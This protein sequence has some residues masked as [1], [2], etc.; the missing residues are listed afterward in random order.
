MTFPEA[1]RFTWADLEAF[2]EDGYRREII[3]G[4]LLVTPAPVGRHQLAVVELVA[5]LR[6][7]KRADTVV[8][9]APYDWH[10]PDGGDVEPDVL[11]I[12]RAD[13]DPDGPLAETA[14]P[15]LVVEVLSPSHPGTDRLLKRD[16]Y[17]RFGVPA[18]W[19]V[20]PVVPAVT[21]LWL[22]GDCYRVAAEVLGDEVFRAD[23]PFPVTFTPSALLM[24]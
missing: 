6:R 8:L 3:G 23:W 10:L 5:L 15:L 17:E 1:R 18:Y 22:E 24:P 2:P 16:T 12:R 20:D 4:A 14:T 13:F 19:I 21:A 11:V 7:A 9:A